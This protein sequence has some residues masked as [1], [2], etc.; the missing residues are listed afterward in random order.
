VAGA[1]HPVVRSKR[2][3][4]ALAALLLLVANVDVLSAA[5]LNGGISGLGTGESSSPTTGF[6]HLDTSQCVVGNVPVSQSE[7]TYYRCTLEY[8]IDAVPDNAVVTAATLRVYTDSMTPCGGGACGMVLSG[9]VGNAVTTLSDLTAGSPIGEEAMGTGSYSQ[10]DV[11]SFVKSVLAGP[12]YPIAGFNLAGD[13]QNPAGAWTV[14]GH[15][16]GANPPTLVI[17]YGIPTSVT[18]AVAAAGTGTVEGEGSSISCPGTCTGMY[19]PGAQVK[20]H[21]NPSNGHAFSQWVGAPCAGQG[22]TCS[23]TMPDTA[24]SV[25][26]AFLSTAPVTAAPTTPPK[27]QAPVQTSAPGDPTAA[28][29][30]AVATTL[31]TDAVATV[32]PSKPAP[33]IVGIGDPNAQPAADGGIPGILIVLVV[34]AVIAVGIGFGVYRYAATKAPKT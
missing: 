17:T 4:V 13:A 3:L 10:F 33:T 25:T 11:E 8:D 9:Y 19:L 29:G 6:G 27:T 22:S 31:P 2:V 28:P 16:A 21:A 24:V 30:T 26:A 5:T 23:F 14:V 20:L 15:P 12:D 1:Y 32:E 7:T 18:V 34:A